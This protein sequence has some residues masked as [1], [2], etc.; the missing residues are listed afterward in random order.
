MRRTLIEEYQ[1]AHDCNLVVMI[2]LIYPAS[3][4][5]LAELLEAVDHSKDLHLMLY[6][7]GG[8]GDAA[9]RLAR[10]CQKASR[11]FTVVVPDSAKSA[12]TIVAL[13]AHQII[14]GPTS[15]LGPVDP[16]IPLGERR[17]A[18]AKDLITAVDRAMREV[19]KRPDTWRL[20]TAML[21]GINATTAQQ[22]RSALTAT[23][24]IV[25][26]AV[27]SN[28]DRSDADI[29]DL[30]K[31]IHKPLISAPSSHS[32]VI[33]AREAIGAG[34]PVKELEPAD[35]QWRRIWHLWVQYFALG[36]PHLMAYESAKASQVYPLD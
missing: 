16:Q 22:A 5:Y 6:S 3:V 14:M 35:P 13:G 11:E 27:S 1:Q 15:D 30:C 4:T 33:G 28:P 8:D 2:D 23:G 20:H 10:M 24:D 19:E 26:K 9:V 18:S 32:A 25:R 17:W 7:P 29:R 21:T 34:L 12:A 36:I 31:K